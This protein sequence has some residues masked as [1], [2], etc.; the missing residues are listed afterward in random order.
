MAAVEQADFHPLVR[1]DVGDELRADGF[2]R[3][4]ALHEVVLDHPLV[5]P[6]HE[7]E[8]LDPGLPGLVDHVLQHRTVDHRH[9]LLGHRFGGR[10]KPGAETRHGKHRLANAFH[11]RPIDRHQVVNP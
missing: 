6:G 5:A 3:G 9:H 2:P 10:Q 7:D 11:A 1:L 8:V 4:S